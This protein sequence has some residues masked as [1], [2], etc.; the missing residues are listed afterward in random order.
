MEALAEPGL[1]HLLGTLLSCGRRN[2]PAE[3]LRRGVLAVTGMML[4]VSARDLLPLYLSLE[5]MTLW[6]Q[7]LVDPSGEPG[8]ERG[9]RQVFPSG[10]L[11]LRISDL[12]D[13]SNLRH[14]RHYG[15]CRRRSAIPH[16]IGSNLLLVIAMELVAAGLASKVATVPLRTWALD[17]Y[18]G[19]TSPV[20]AFLAAGSKA[21]GLAMFG[22]VCLTAYGSQAQVLSVILG[23]LAGLSS[24]VGSIVA[25]SQT[26]M[27]RL[28]VYSSIAHGGYALLGLIAGTHPVASATMTYAFF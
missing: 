23:M 21:V 3:F 7:I 25:L 27:K 16:S 6:S 26:D 19:A 13:K 12:R 22:R 18:Q 17:A 10:F 8:I 24:V 2:A 11:R 1:R 9:W 28:L 20:A 15:P 14:C 5:L 4:A